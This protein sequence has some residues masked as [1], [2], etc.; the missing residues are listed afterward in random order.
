VERR[1]LAEQ[2]FARINAARQAQGLPPLAWDEGLYQAALAR[3]MDMWG[4]RY[5]GHHDP[6]SGASLIP[7]PCGEVLSASTDPVASW[8]SSP[9]HWEIL[10]DPGGSAGAV[11]LIQ[12]PG[13]RMRVTSNPLKGQEISVVQISVGL[14]RR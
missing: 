2:A 14:V 3:A 13:I 10:M 4:R 12:T 8:K 9:P 6:N 7:C 1:D 11:A 5:I